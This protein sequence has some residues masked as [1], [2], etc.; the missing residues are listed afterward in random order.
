MKINFFTTKNNRN[1]NLENDVNVLKSDVNIL[2][3]D[4]NI[5][6]TDVGILKNEVFSI[7]N[8]LNSLETKME[9]KFLILDHDLSEIKIIL[10]SIEKNKA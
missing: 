8:K 4:V 2:K 3:G 6:K 9:T 7:N 5:L 1:K 10:K